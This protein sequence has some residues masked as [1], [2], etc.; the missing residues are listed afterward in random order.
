[1]GNGRNTLFWLDKWALDEPLS[2]KFPSLF[3]IC[4]RPNALVAEIWRIPD[5]RPNFRRSFGSIELSQW[6]ALDLLLAPISLTMVPDSLTWTL[7]PSGMFSTASLYS[8]LHQGFAVFRFKDLWKVRLPLKIKYFLWQ[9]ARGRIPSGDQVQKR[10]GP[11]DGLCP[12]CGEAEDQNHILFSCVLAKFCW[13]VFSETLG[14]QW[15]PVS[16][17]SLFSRLQRVTGQS[18]RL[19][20]LAAASLLWSLWLIRNKDLIEGTF[21]KSPTDAIYKIIV[22]LQL[23]MPL[24]RAEDRSG[25]RTTISNIK[26]KIT[27]LRQALDE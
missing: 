20:W 12:L 3:A 2:E 6:Q 24:S 21:I 26:D 23:W 18:Y 4:D 17:S 13:S 25:I 9:V 11:G 1:V 22:F 7:E 8:A 16:F 10:H 19:L 14:Q 27:S 15:A 5:A